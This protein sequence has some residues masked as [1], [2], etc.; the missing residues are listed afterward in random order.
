MKKK[1]KVYVICYTAY[2]KL[3]GFTVTTDSGAVTFTFTGEMDFEKAKERVE[4][5]FAV[6]YKG[7]PDK[8]SINSVCNV[9]GD[10]F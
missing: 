10:F 5:H 9:T 1:E 4:E 7:R 6:R 8:I 3:F 2:W